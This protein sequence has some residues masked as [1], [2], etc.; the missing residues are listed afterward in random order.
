MCRITS[1]ILTS[2]TSLAICAELDNTAPAV[3]QAHCYSLRLNGLRSAMDM[4]QTLTSG[5]ARH[6]KFSDMDCSTTMFNVG[7]LEGVL[8]V[9]CRY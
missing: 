5:K 8:V 9:G 1:H 3:A 6:K 2:L 7:T 4:V